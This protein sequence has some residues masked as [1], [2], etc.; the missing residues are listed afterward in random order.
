MALTTTQVSQLYVSIFGRVSEGSG[1]T[2][3][4]TEATNMTTTAEAMFAL[5]NVAT[6]FGVSNYTS[7]TNVRTV[8]EAI[9][10]NLFAKAPADDTAGITYWIGKVTTDGQTLGSVVADLIAA[11]QLTANA[12]NA[13]DQFNNKVALSDY[14]ANNLTAHTTDAAFQAFSA[15]VDHTAAS[16]V[17]AKALVLAAVPYVANPGSTFTLTTGINKGTAFTGTAK[18]DTFNA[19][20]N[21]TWT[22][23]DAIDGGE[24]KDTFSVLTSATAAPGLATVTNV[25]NIDINTTGAGFTLDTTAMAG[26]E[27]LTVSASTA[28]ALALT[29][30]ATTTLGAIATGSGTITLVGGKGDLSLQSGSGAIVVGEDTTPTAA[31]ANNFDAVSTTSTGN[32]S[33]ADNSGTAGAIGSTIKTVSLNGVATGD[34]DMNGLTTL[35]MIGATGTTTVTSAAAT[36]ALTVNISGALSATY[37][38]V[39]ANA[40]TVTV[41]SAAAATM[42][43]GTFALATTATVSASAN[44]IITTLAL[45]EATAITLSGAGGTLAAST[46]TVAKMVTLTITG[47]KLVTV[48]ATNSTLTAMTTVDASD[49]TGGVTMGQAL[50]VDDAYTGG[51]GVDTLTIGA[52]TVATT[53][54]AGNDVLTIT[55]GTAAN[56]TIAGGDGTGDTLVMTETLADKA[57][58][59]S[60]N[61]IQAG[62]MSGFEILSLTTVTQS[63]NVDMAQLDNI[64]TVTATRASALVLDNFVN[65]GT[66]ISTDSQSTL[67]TIN[68]KEALVAGHN[69]DTV[70]YTLN[71]ATSGGAVDQGVTVMAGVETLNILSTRSGI[72]VAGDTNTLGLTIANIENIVVT[73]DVDLNLDVA[74]AAASFESIDASANTNGLIVTAAGAAQGVTLKGSLLG[75]NTMTGGNGSD[76]ITGGAGIDVIIGGTGADIV[77]TGAGVDTITFT[78]EV[79]LGDTLTGGAGADAFIQ[80][81]TIST[82]TISTIITDFD[83]GTSTTKV[84]DIELST[85]MLEGMTG[86]ID[87]VDTNA[88]NGTGGVVV[89]VT[90]DAQTVTGADLIVI[91]NATYTNTTTL[92][93]GLDTAGASTVTYSIAV[94]ADDAIMYMYSD[95]TDAYMALVVAGG[96]NINSDGADTAYNVVTFKG[97][98]LAGLLNVDTTDYLSIA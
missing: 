53:L 48:G 18:D 26:V 45:A 86:V 85:T 25:E 7:A 46:F 6:F 65:G 92:L 64:A 14:A 10:L 80:L 75:A 43:A 35:N 56:G 30:A 50:A 83:F 9:Y 31:A 24:G 3:W 94:S 37:S 68:V 42:T 54:G 72:V 36:R 11:A 22:S 33:I 13:Q 32:H 17:T 97:I 71:G 41:N 57:A 91:T 81:N 27:T 2:F 29:I 55:A 39:D 88:D 40:T 4:K 77:S 76:A 21:N 98:N 67:T 44:T 95:G 23:F 79:T 62:R 89:Q 70:N 84:D 34:L 90:A 1:N 93:A 60:L 16:L 15:N 78:S 52:S 19:L 96:T 74:I 61:G 12:G 8:V 28:G 59:L 66:Y 63:K 5:D 38:V 51:S 20:T 69:S 87:L 58:G 82:T 49:N 73:G 47:N